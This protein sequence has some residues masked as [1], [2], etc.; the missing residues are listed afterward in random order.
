[1]IE[2]V[3]GP[4]PASA[5]GATSMHDHSI[6]DCRMLYRAA[7]CAP[8]D[9]L[10][11]A[12]SVDFLRD[13]ALASR[14]NLIL[15]DVDTAVAELGRGREAGLRGYVDLT[16]WGGGEQYR[17]L[18]EISRRSGLH[19]VAGYGVYL[20]RPHPDW[21]RACDDEALAARIRDAVTRHLPGVDYRAGI[22]GI[23]GT[24]A[25]VTASEARVVAAAGRAAGETGSAVVVRVDPAA[26]D[27]LAM[28]ERLGQAGCTA[29]QVIFP[30]TDELFGEGTPADISRL[31]SWAE[32]GATLEFCFGNEFRMRPGF[33]QH[34]DAQRLQVLMAL[35]E[36]GCI[37]RLV[38]GHS[39]FMKIQ[40]QRHGG[41]GYSHLLQTI[42]PTL[43][44]RGVADTEL[45]QMLVGNPCRLLDRAVSP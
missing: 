5:W 17:W 36:R 21:V 38:L 18:P 24:G 39:V 14:D 7:D 25:P 30:N 10:V 3:L 40:L 43:R 27:G 26:A 32:A 20:D 16:S 37:Q 35:I 11:T 31:Q 23:I 29:A 1:M 12:A 15:D 45:Q 44:A 9:E 41:Y 8:P 4:V 33:P 28:L 6:S 2:T 34:T 19:I 42:V 22:I 13:H